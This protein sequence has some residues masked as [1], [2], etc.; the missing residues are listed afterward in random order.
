[1]AMTL[2]LY[3]YHEMNGTTLELDL[4]SGLLGGGQ[5]WRIVDWKPV[6]PPPG[7]TLPVVERIK[8][9][10]DTTSHD[11]LARLF[12]VLDE[13]R[14]LA[15]Q[16]IRD[17]SESS[18]TWLYA[19][20]ES[21][22]G[23]RRALV[24]AVGLKWTTMPTALHGGAESNR[25]EVTL[26]VER[27]PVWEDP[28][29][30]S[31]SIMLTET[32]GAAIV[33]D[34]TAGA[35]PHDVLGD[36]P[37]R[38][39]PLVIRTDDTGAPLGRLWMGFRSYDKHGDVDDFVPIWEC[40]AG[41]LGTDA[42][43]AADATASPG[44]G[45]N[46]KV[47]I[48]PGTAT[49]AKRLTIELVDVA[50]NIQSRQF[51]DFLWLMRFS[52][53]GADVWEV[54]LRFGYGGMADADFVQRDIVP[55]TNTS[56]DYVEMGRQRVPLRDIQVFPISLMPS[57]NDNTFA[58]QIWA[59]RTSGSGALD[60]DCLLPVPIDEGWCKSW[61]FALPSNYDADWLWGEGPKGKPSVSTV[62]PAGFDYAAAFS[63][64]DFRV[65]VGDGR[66]VIV[67]AGPFSHSISTGIST[68]YFG[69][70]ERWLN[71]RGAE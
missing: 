16:F 30:T 4:L 8:V 23:Q 56:W 11:E 48:T 10:C 51:G 70:Y 2:K 25:V 5:G 69:Y 45:G 53:A 57:I 59:R 17:S 9:L 13:L 36:A 52:T 20:M 63:Y 60:L 18:P 31:A 28:D 66:L 3:R 62:I 39:L 35:T 71:L 12:Q 54:Q 44:G 6:S 19:Q 65:P 38:I 26:T 15:E 37:A 47:T 40:E 55:L 50:N 1:M 27:E 49:W 41:T 22:T 34:Y 7:D 68:T 42:A 64:H 46:T 67:Y 58:V 21:E 61:D 14:T 43:L 33:Y 24:R 32:A 29:Y